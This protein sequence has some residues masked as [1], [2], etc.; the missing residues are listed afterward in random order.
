[1]YGGDRVLCETLSTLSHEG[2]SN[3]CDGQNQI[4]ERARVAGFS[5]EQAQRIANEEKVLRN[6]N[7]KSVC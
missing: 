4:S 1:M 7:S 3:F 2:L 5:E 6:P